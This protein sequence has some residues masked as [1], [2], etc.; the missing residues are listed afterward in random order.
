MLL[1]LGMGPSACGTDGMIERDEPLSARDIDWIA[2]LHL[3]SIDDSLPSLL[4]AAY[5]RRFYRFVA[6]SEVETLFFERIDGD[7]ASVCLV[8]ME[9]ESLHGRIVKGTSPSLFWYALL[10]LC[11]SPDSR[12]FLRQFVTDRLRGAEEAPGG[13]EI[14]Y[15]F[16][17]PKRRGQ[18]LGARLLAR[19]EAHL[20]ERNVSVYHVK[21]VDEPDNRALAFYDQSGFRRAGRLVEAGRTFVLF[22]KALAES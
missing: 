22:Q 12:R 10:A 6:A 1:S 15:I 13:P 21:T 16:T 4:G 3:A 14:T 7:V 2:T 18:R 20:R 11:R 5:L 17:D 19:V 9:P 8:S